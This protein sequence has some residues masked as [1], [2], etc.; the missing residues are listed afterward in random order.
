MRPVRVSDAALGSPVLVPAV[1]AVGRPFGQVLSNQGAVGEKYL[2]T[3]D[4]TPDRTLL[5]PAWLFANWRANPLEPGGPDFPGNAPLTVRAQVQFPGAGGNTVVTPLY[6]IAGADQVQLNPGGSVWLVALCALP[7]GVSARLVVYANPGASGRVPLSI[8]VS[9]ADD[10]VGHTRGASV[11]EPSWGSPVAAQPQA[12]EGTFA[13]IACVARA[14]GREAFY[15]VALMGDSITFGNGDFPT[16]WGY[17]VRALSAAGVPW[18]SLS[19]GG[20]FLPS[21][22]TP[23]APHARFRMLQATGCVWVLEALGTNNMLLLAILGGTDVSGILTDKVAVWRYLDAGGFAVASVV[24]P[25]VQNANPDIAG[26][27]DVVRTDLVRWL[28]DGAPV[29]V[30]TG[31]AARVGAQGGDIARTLVLDAQRR[32]S[33][34]PSGPPH[35][36]RVIFDVGA[37]VEASPGANQWAPGMT[38]D[39]VHPTSAGAQAMAQAVDPSVFRRL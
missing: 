28:R 34:A 14:S 25:P 1:P 12:T 7:A 24:P 33:V 3:F 8:P 20:E 18:L 22:S 35:P 5:Y 6:T 38:T 30:R 13:P 19:A 27:L 31:Q 15:P 11:T 17:A 9:A 21:S 10:G 36:V 4:F 39:L 37:M 29:N 16:G 23:H 26:R 2:V 32:V